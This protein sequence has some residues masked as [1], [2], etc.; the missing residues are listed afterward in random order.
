[1]LLIRSFVM[2]VV[3]GDGVSQDYL[4]GAVYVCGCFRDEIWW[5]FN[6]HLKYLWFSEIFLVFL[7]AL[8]Q[9]LTNSI[10]RFGLGF[11]WIFVNWGVK[12]LDYFFCEA[13]SY[14]E[15]IFELVEDV[16]QLSDWKESLYF[17]LGG[18]IH[19]SFSISILQTT[20]KSRPHTIQ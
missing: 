20:K 4:L 19:S 3:D 5:V 9:A 16:N 2:M 14:L 11:M 13:H 8:I 17:T 10:L 12:L 15:Q 6:N 1:M 18:T 7:L